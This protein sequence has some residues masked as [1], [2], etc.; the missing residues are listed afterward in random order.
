M[1][2]LR[3]G[4]LTGCVGLSLVVAACAQAEVVPTRPPISAANVIA[5]QTARTGGVP[6][7]APGGGSAGAQLFQSNGC[8]ACHMVGG[9]GGAVGPNLSKIGA[10]A[11][12]RKPGTDAAAYIRE[13]IVN[14]N[15]FLAPGYQA[16][17][18]PAFAQFPPADLDALV[19][20]L[21]EQ[22]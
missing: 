22:K 9:Q 5:T 11:A 4:L 15:A 7:P 1:N 12:T 19:E 2:R 16:G 13:S 3:A 10:D 14:P 6:A 17:L 21:A 8:I 20:Y 18:M